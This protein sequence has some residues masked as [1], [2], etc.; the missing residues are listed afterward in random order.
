MRRFFIDPK[1][2]QSE[3]PRIEGPDA[4]HLRNVLRLKPGADVVL[5]DGQGLEYEARITSISADSA[6]FKILGKSQPTTESPIEITAGISLLKDKKMDTLVRQL[7]ELG[8][9]KIAP[10]LSKRSIAKPKTLEKRMERWEKIASE[11][12]KQCRRSHI[13]SIMPLIYF[14]D[15][16]LEL[17]NH[18][19]K[20]ILWEE[21]PLPL[22]QAISQFIEKNYPKKDDSHIKSAAI[23]IGPEGG[24]SK[25]EAGLA[26]SNGFIPAGLGPRI[27]RAETAAVA[28]CTIIGHLFGD[29]GR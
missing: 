11:S 17:K 14:K 15:A 23:L 29:I 4:N 18:P 7:T 13:P 6:T 5:F 3:R 25:E 22:S 26:I 16:V 19:L 28:A 12:L 10:I 27:L 21:E 1:I 8:V 2:V 20:I 24:F 9:M